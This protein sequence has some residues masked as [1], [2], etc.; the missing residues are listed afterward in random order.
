MKNENTAKA[1]LAPVVFVSSEALKEVSNTK[2]QRNPNDLIIMNAEVSRNGQKYAFIPVSEI[3]IDL[4]YQ[5]EQSER[6]VDSLVAGWN[7]ERY[8]P[9]HVA[10]R[11]GRFKAWDGGKR[12][13]AQ[14]KMGKENVYCKLCSMDTLKDEITAYVEQGKYV[15]RINP[16]D[17]FKAKLFRG[18][19]RQVTIKRICDEYGVSIKLDR[20]RKGMKYDK[21]ITNISQIESMYG[22]IG[23][24]GLRWVFD[25]IHAMTLDM[26]GKKG[27]NTILLRALGTIYAKPIDSYEKIQRALHEFA[28]TRPCWIALAY[29]T[30]AKREFPMLGDVPATVNL[31]ESIVVGK[32]DWAKR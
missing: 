26:E 6:A 3:D 28:L 30:V 16:A 4:D 19:E 1:T 7:E 15:T 9:I 22:T 14:V 5:R 18:D 8:E 20:N 12:L 31:L 24:K 27:Y 10:Y 21:T 11:D 23:E 32:T 29:R 13:R 17:L 2:A 25:T